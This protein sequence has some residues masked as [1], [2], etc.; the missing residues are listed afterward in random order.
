MQHQHNRFVKTQNL[1]S[2]LIGYNVI[3]WI[4]HKM[5]PNVNN[6][7]II[8]WTVCD[9]VICL[10]RYYCESDFFMERG[11]ESELSLVVVLVV[12]RLLVTMVPRPLARPRA[13]TCSLVRG[14]SR[15]WFPLE[16]CGLPLERCGRPLD[17]VRPPLDRAM[18]RTRPPLDRHGRPLV[19]RES[20]GPFDSCCRLI[21]R[22]G[23]PLSSR[24]SPGPLERLGRPLGKR[25]SPEPLEI[26]DRALGRRDS[27][28]LLE[29]L[30]LLLGR[31]ES[32]RPLESC[33]LPLRTA[34][35]GG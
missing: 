6:I 24:P 9:N 28:R 33:G 34:R 22:L 23:C 35:D 32:P 11:V 3:G 21:G 7:F 30:G 10:R 15:G 25:E 26:P 16:R 18:V 17:R 13:W 12:V 5:V 8:T 31:R 2:R 19:M 27:P 1:L 29:R 4:F 20:P 14:R